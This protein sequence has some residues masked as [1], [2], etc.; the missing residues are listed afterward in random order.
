MNIFC[1]FIVQGTVGFAIGAGTNDLAIR[2]VFWALFAKKKKAIAE[3]VQEVVSRE[4]MSPEKIAARLA[5]P[6]VAESLRQSVQSALT[7]AA[8]RTWPSIETLARTYA[9]LRVDALQE[10]LAAL[11]ADALADRFAAPSF[12]TE[13]L[14]PFLEE[15]WQ[16]LAARQPAG[17]LPSTTRD[18]LASLPERLAEIVLAP[19][20]RDRLCAVIADGLR[21][22]MTEYP[23]PA[24]LL[25]AANIAELATLAGSRTRLL[26]EELSG[27]LAMPPAQEALRTAIRD[28]VQAR[29]NSHGTLGTILKG[30]SGAT[31]VENQ[32][33]RF[34]ET[35][36]ATVR[37]R[38]SGD[39]IEENRM[40]G[41]VETAV[42]KLLAR[43]WAELLDTDAPDN[44]ERHVKA[45]LGSD[46][47]RDMTRL[48]FARVTASVLES[49][50][51]GTLAD[52]AGLL[53]ANGSIAPYLAWLAETLHAA[54][55]APEIRPQIEIQTLD[56][57]Q[58]LCASPIRPP[59]RFLPEG[60][61]SQLASLA[62]E[63][64]LGF[65]HDNLAELVE[66]TRIWDIISESIIVYDDKK[67][68][69]IARSVANREL[70]WVTILGGLIGF[71]VGIA[72]GVLLLILD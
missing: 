55:Q 61:A 26:G 9:G 29:L 15:R 65:A 31:I 16:G 68:E 14:R 2:W 60:T 44:I 25:G 32:L 37:S 18:L 43:T 3:A 5:A 23:T 27:L 59:A 22:W 69:A 62:A 36:P 70:R 67:M 63:V 30:L 13:I 41:L 24:S 38:F 4:L 28:A 40:R 35:L 19:E 57:V 1:Q 39:G 72:Q 51:R 42:R 49:L 21:T 46:A 20:H 34:C 45:L 11:A 47:V 50:Q 8:A 58:R 54:L 56:A 52:A 53:T 48:G 6:E 71:V 66:R 33:A 7:E 64:I 12:R 10:R 17:L